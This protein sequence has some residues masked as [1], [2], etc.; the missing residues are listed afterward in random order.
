[1]SASWNLMECFPFTSHARFKIY[2]KHIQYME[3]IDF[4]WKC[5]N[6]QGNEIYSIIFISRQ[7]ISVNYRNRTTNL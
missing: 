3:C 2:G 5:K 1:M 7:S 6:T 4:V